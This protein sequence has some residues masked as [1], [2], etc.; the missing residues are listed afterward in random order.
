MVELKR[1]NNTT[2]SRIENRTLLQELRPY[3]GMSK[4]GHACARNLWYSFRWAAQKEISSRMRRLFYRGHREEQAI[5]QE[6]ESV[7]VICYGYQIELEMAFGHSK[8]HID[9][10]AI[11]VIEAPKTEHL[12]EFK[13]MNDKYFKQI[14][15]EGVKKSKPVYYAQSQIYM[16]KEGLTRA[17]FIAANKNTDEYYF[18]RLHLNEPYAKELEAKAEYIIISEEPPKKLS[19]K[20]TWFECK[21]CDYLEVC[22]YSQAYLKTCRTCQRCDIELKGKWK[23]ALHLIELS[24]EQQKIGCDSYESIRI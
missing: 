9:G 16:A 24:T 10:K 18:E 1:F 11:G 3:L 15:K 4:I 12:L 6:L 21:W 17:L 22:H 13:T 23:C 5:I 7:G 20:P 8:G 14:K 2:L 19:D